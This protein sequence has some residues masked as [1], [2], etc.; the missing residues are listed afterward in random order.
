MYNEIVST[1][2]FIMTLIRLQHPRHVWLA[3]TEDQL[4][5]N[6]CVSLKARCSR[7]WMKRDTTRNENK[8]RLTIDSFNE[9]KLITRARKMS[10][11]K[12]K[13]IL[14]GKNAK[15]IVYTNPG[16]VRYTRV[17][18]YDY[19]SHYYL[20]CEGDGK[21]WDENLVWED[22]KFPKKIDRHCWL[23]E[24]KNAS[25]RRPNKRKE[26][27]L[28]NGLTFALQCLYGDYDEDGDEEYRS[29]FE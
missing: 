7:S 25:T 29:I 27:L 20:Y 5:H 12:D 8:R 19:I 16:E 14:G 4:W 3:D 2:N 26:E 24:M 11:I 6:L 18:G 23:G 9:C 13:L 17:A 10:N 28:D 21:P 1:A 15:I 22:R